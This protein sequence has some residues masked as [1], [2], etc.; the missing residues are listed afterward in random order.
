[1]TEPYR[2]S[3]GTEGRIFT[4]KFC[5]RCKHDNYT[6]EKP[7]DGCEILVMTL[8]YGIKDEE[9]PKE[10]VKDSDGPRCTAFESEEE[11]E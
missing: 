1:M 4:G 5:D 10:W 3:N 2:P 8:G 6:D 11:S 7:E 9:Y